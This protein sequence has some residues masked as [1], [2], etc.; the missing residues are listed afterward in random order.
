MIYSFGQCELDTERLELR[1]DGEL[2][3]VEPQVFSLLVLL[4]ENR[5]HVVS[6]DDLIVAVWEGRVVSDASLSSRISAARTAVGDTGRSQAIIRTMPKR[7]F[8]FVADILQDKAARAEPQSGAYDYQAMG[9]SLPDKPSIAVLPFDNKSGDPE[10]EYF[11]GG[12]AEDVDDVRK[13]DSWSPHQ[14]I[15]FCTTPDGVQI[16]YA[17]A[18]AGPP[19]VKAANWLNHL[20]YDWQSPVWR[21]LFRALAKDRL[22]VRYDARGNGLSDWEVEDISFEAFVQD[23]ETVVDAVALKR[24]AL[25]GISQGCAVSIK[26]AIQHPERVICLVLHGGYARGRFHRGSPDEIERSRVL[27]TLV[28]QG[29][30]QDNPAFRQMFSSLLI[31]DA[32]PEQ[33]QWFNDLQRVSASPENAIRIREAYDDINI[34]DDLPAISVPTLVLH[35]RNDAAVPFE[36]GRRMAGMIPGVKFVPLEGQN[37]L[38]L[39]DEPAWPRFLE[40][41]RGFLGEFLDSVPN[42]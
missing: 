26:Y 11:S 18:G 14:S 12:I 17:T 4:I 2:Q 23:L 10:Q 16:A 39:Q 41:V 32:S 3:A 31:P 9:K 36:E 8:R 20:E 1:R 24:F 25:F 38:I 29:W 33:M 13:S 34:S 40:E 42:S 37:H 15:H 7:G 22:L 30:G 5:D 6:K 19:L 27:N 28:R 21:H 35:C